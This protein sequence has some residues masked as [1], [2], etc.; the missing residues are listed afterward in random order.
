MQTIIKTT[1]WMMILVAAFSACEDEGGSDLTP[2]GKGGSMARFA[3][4][5]EYLY[6]LDQTHLQTFSTASNTF[7]MVNEIYT[8]EGMETIFVQD[9]Y[10]YV[11]ATT[12]MY[13]YNI[14]NP[15]QP[16]FVFQYSH[17]RSCDPVVV[18]GNRAYVTLRTGSRCGGTV[19]TLEIL[20]ITD[21]FN[22]TLVA[23]YNMKSPHGLAVDGT[24]LFVCEGDYGFKVYNI[25]GERNIQL[26]S[27]ND[28]H[29]AYDVIAHNGL[30]QVTGDDGLFQYRYSAAGGLQFLS[31][32]PVTPAP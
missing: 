29:H 7:E 5:G 28:T 26:I 6:V 11:G 31:K 16:E 18:Q 32:I 4:G 25:A 8:G 1:L 21:R 12:A 3:I 2:S 17:L 23:G 30:L 27:N 14:E 24:V 10:L 19:N 22:P 15:A 20:D 13:I 9:K